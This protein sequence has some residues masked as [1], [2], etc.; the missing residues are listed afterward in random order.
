[1]TDTTTYTYNGDNEL[2]QQVDSVAGTTTFG[3]DANGSQTTTTVGGTLTQT[4]YYDVRNRLQK[5]VNS[6]GTTTY[7]Y[8][9]AGDR[10]QETTGSTTTYY[11]IDSN[12]PTGYA[13]PIEVRV[14]SATGTRTSTSRPPAPMRWDAAARG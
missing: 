6:S 13:K 8:D 12:N 4:N 1:M 11:L 14:G 5:V 10:V 9:D 7:V 2:T 3:Y